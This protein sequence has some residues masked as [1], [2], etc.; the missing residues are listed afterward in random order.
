MHYLRLGDGLLMDAYRPFWYDLH[1]DC[2]IGFGIVGCWMVSGGWIP[3]FPFQCRAEDHCAVMRLVRRGGWY[4][5]WPRAGA[6]YVLVGR[7]SVHT[8]TLSS[9]E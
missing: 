4:W 8:C 2:V 1:G 7:C 3:F 9:V 6:G 5:I